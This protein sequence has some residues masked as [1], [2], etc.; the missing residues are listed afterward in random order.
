MNYNN[1]I[2]D[3]ST[4]VYANNNAMPGENP[5]LSNTDC[6]AYPDTPYCNSNTGVCLMSTPNDIQNSQASTTMGISDLQ[7]DDDGIYDFGN[8]PWGVSRNPSSSTFL[9]KI[10]DFAN[11][12]SM[13]DESDLY[14]NGQ[15]IYWTKMLVFL[16]AL[17][18]FV[19]VVVFVFSRFRSGGNT[20][21]AT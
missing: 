2:V 15:S 17:L 13:A 7:S 9:S 12:D 10:R 14:Q 1:H 20:K 5:C 11:G 8:S 3:D 19:I 18:I 4:S 6:M 16:L 21:V